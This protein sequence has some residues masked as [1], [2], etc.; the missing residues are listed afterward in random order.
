MSLKF[1]KISHPNIIVIPYQDF[2][3]A[4][5]KGGVFIAHDDDNADLLKAKF[6]CTFLSFGGTNGYFDE[7]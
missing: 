3:R 6:A 7:N 5:C 1:A 2:D 4:E